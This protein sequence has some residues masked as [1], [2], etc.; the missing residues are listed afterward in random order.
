MNMVPCFGG[1]M[2]GY[3]AENV[4]PEIEACTEDGDQV[5]VYKLTQFTFPSENGEQIAF[6]SAYVHGEPPAADEVYRLAFGETRLQ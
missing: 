5:F 1:I 2:D 4:G 3:T 6:C